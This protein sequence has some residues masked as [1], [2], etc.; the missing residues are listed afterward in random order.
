MRT[1]CG[2]GALVARTIVRTMTSMPRIEL[3]RLPSSPRTVL[4]SLITN[5]PSSRGP[6]RHRP[7]TL[8]LRPGFRLEP[9]QILRNRS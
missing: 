3:A 5:A 1:I 8:V 4:P 6:N 9:R 2:K 7:G